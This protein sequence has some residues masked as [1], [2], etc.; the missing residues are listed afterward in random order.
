MTVVGT[1]LLLL[2]CFPGT[3]HRGLWTSR[4]GA[5]CAC[6]VEISMYSGL[7]VCLRNTYPQEV[8][9]CCSCVLNLLRHIILRDHFR[10][11]DTDGRWSIFFAYMVVVMW[12]VVI[13]LVVLWLYL[14]DSSRVA[15]LCLH[16][17]GTHLF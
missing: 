10:T 3:F 4:V 9:G 7:H 12:N 1:E 15:G 2:Q 11:L 8:V 6:R 13:T 17:S 5:D 16:Y 14:N